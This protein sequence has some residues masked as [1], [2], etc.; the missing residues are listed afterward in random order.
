MKKKATNEKIAQEIKNRTKGF[1]CEIE[2]ETSSMDMSALGGSGVSIKV[3]GRELDT[4]KEI[5]TDV[6]E[7]VTDVKVRRIFQTE[8]RRRPRKCVWW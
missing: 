4:I 3:K 7:I 8:L 5:A 1:P 6:A 2:V